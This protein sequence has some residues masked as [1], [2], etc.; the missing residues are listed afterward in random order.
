MHIKHA[1]HTHAT[2]QR[3][4]HVYIHTHLHTREDMSDMMITFF[5]G[6]CCLNHRVDITAL[7]GKSANRLI[8]TCP[9]SHTYTYMHMLT[10]H[11]MPLM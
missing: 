8:H 10:F 2:H 1:A 5:I 7:I 6:L 3:T 11:V 4:S 9:S